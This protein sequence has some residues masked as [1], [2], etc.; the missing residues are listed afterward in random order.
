[1]E[2]YKYVSCSPIVCVEK[3]RQ[4]GQELTHLRNS[5]PCGS[6]FFLPRVVRSKA[7]CKT[8]HLHSDNQ[9]VNSTLYPSW[10][11]MSIMVFSDQMRSISKLIFTYEL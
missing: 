5:L 4:I 11:D 6:F 10:L 8:H 3:N 1:M 7:L 2:T 9:N